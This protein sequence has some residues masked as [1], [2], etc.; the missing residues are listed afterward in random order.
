MCW[1]VIFSLLCVCFGEEVTIWVAPD[2]SFVTNNTTCLNNCGA[3]ACP[4]IGFEDAISQGYSYLQNGTA[5]ITIMAFP[6]NYV[7]NKN[8]HLL[9]NYTL[10]IKYVFSFL[11]I[12]SIHSFFSYF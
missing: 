8:S 6:G 4:C 11:F 10:T 2:D 7:G 12:Y 1:L 5:N 3:E 9:V